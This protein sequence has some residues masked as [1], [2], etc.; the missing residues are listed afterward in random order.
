MYET[1]TT[2]YAFRGLSGKDSIIASFEIV[3]NEPKYGKVNLN[4]IL[5]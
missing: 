4:S 5:L 2:H 3:K 1:E